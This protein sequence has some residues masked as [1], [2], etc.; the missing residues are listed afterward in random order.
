MKFLSSLALG[1]GARMNAFNGECREAEPFESTTWRYDAAVSAGVSS[2]QGDSDPWNNEQFL[3]NQASQWQ[4]LTRQE[5]IAVG[6][7]QLSLTPNNDDE[8]PAWENMTNRL[9]CPPRRAKGTWTRTSQVVSLAGLFEVLGQEYTAKDIYDYW[10]SSRVVAAKYRRPGTETSNHTLQR[11]AALEHRG[12]EQ[13]LSEEFASA[14]G[15]S[16]D[17][18]PTRASNKRLE[19]IGREIGSKILERDMHPWA[20]FKPAPA[21][22]VS[23]MSMGWEVLK[24]TLLQWD[25]MSLAHLG[26]GVREA[27]SNSAGGACAGCVGQ[28]LYTCMGSRTVTRDGQPVA[29]GTQDAIQICCG[30]TALLSK[31]FQLPEGQTAWLC[32]DCHNDQT[33]VQ[34]GVPNRLI[35]LFPLVETTSGKLTVFIPSKGPACVLALFHAPEEWSFPT[36]ANDWDDGQPTQ[37][38]DVYLRGNAM[39]PMKVVVNQV[40]RFVYEYTDSDVVWNIA[41]R[42]KGRKPE[43]FKPDRAYGQ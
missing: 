19:L 12:Q 38:R 11:Q 30:N 17:R 24:T 4:P 5:Q 25:D 22:G 16:A 40:A 42:Y 10:L 29:A 26:A 39:E 6:K 28:P 7:G 3:V 14:F 13:H 43:E 37:A 1:V 15:L 2:W 36:L 20:Q 41:G 31:N 35:R 9:L 21:G 34:N 27:V 23:R 33:P 32:Q 18:M 8:Q